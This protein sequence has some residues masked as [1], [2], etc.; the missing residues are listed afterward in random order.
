MR[1][2]FLRFLPILLA[3]AACSGQILKPRSEPDQMSFKPTGGRALSP[4]QTR[5][6]MGEV[7]G[8]WLYGEGVGETALAAGTVAAFPPYA[9]VLLGNAVLSLSGYEPIWLSD[10]LPAEEKEQWNEIYDTVGAAPGRFN[11]AVAGEE[12]RTREVVNERYKRLLKQN[13]PPAQ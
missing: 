2:V 12:F 3:L 5:E 8:N 11:A 6:V 7:G 4:Q 13:Q 1:F 10:A 9:A